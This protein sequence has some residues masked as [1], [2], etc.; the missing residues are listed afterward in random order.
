MT[1]RLIDQNWKKLLKSGEA[2]HKKKKQEP[3][4]YEKT[5]KD[6]KKEIWFE[7]D[8]ELLDA[9]NST[10]ALVPN[11]SQIGNYNKIV[12][13]GKCLFGFDGDQSYKCSFRL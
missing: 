3:I 9:P 12:A 8:Q 1:K 6:G 4:N 13:L 5:T 7:V 10:D 2:T 11:K